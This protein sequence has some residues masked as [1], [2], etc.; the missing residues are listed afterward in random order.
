MKKMI[1]VLFSLILLFTGIFSLREVSSQQN[2]ADGLQLVSPTNCPPGGCAAG[3][4][5]NL[6]AEFTVLPKITTRTNTVL[7]FTAPLDGQN[8]TGSNPWDDYSTGWVSTVGLVSTQ[9]YVNSD[10]DGVCVKNL[11]PSEH[12]ITSVNAT[13]L[14]P[15]SDKLEL[16]LRI[17]KSSDISGDIKAYV[18][19]LQANGITWLLSKALTLNI[20]VSFY[21]QPV[22]VAEL[23]SGCG[24]FSPCFVNSGDDLVGGL[25]TGLKDAIDAFSTPMQINILGSYKVKGQTIVINAPHII[26]GFSGSS[27]T[28]EGNICSNPILEAKSG[29]KVDHLIINDGSCVN[30]SRNLIVIDSPQN[31]MIEYNTLTNGYEAIGIKPNSGNTLI[32]FNQITNNVSYAIKRLSDANTGVLNVVANNIFGNRFGFEVDCQSKGFANH[33]YWGV[34][35]DA[36]SKATNCGIKPGKQLG[37]PIKAS[38]PGVDALLVTVKPTKTSYFN[39]LLS[40]NRTSGIDYNIYL[41]NHGNNG[42]ESIPFLN[43][44]SGPM[45]PCS[46]FYDL[47]L[48]QDTLPSDLIL[49]IKY[50]LNSSCVSTI[51]SSNYCNQTNSS[52]FPLWWFDPATNVTE[53]WDMTGASPKGIGASGATGQL[54]SCDMTTKELTVSIDST[55]RPDFSNDLNFTPF[56]VGISLPA[57]IQL[58]SFTG[59]FAVSRVDLKWI[60]ASE[61]NVSGF[62][63]LRSESPNGTFTRITDKITAIGNAFVGGIYNYSD[64]DIV[65]TKSYYYKLEVIDKNGNTIEMHG[66]LNVLTATA[67]PTATATRTITPTFTQTPY[68]SNTPY[69]YISPTRFIPSITPT[70]RIVTSIYKSPTPFLTNVTRTSATTIDPASGTQVLITDFPTSQN[71]QD[72]PIIVITPII[73]IGALTGTPGSSTS[74][75]QP[76]PTLSDGSQT[77]VKIVYNSTQL[78]NSSR[79]DKVSWITI[80]IGAIVGLIMLVLIGWLL[81][82]SRIS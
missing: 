37:A 23:P 35:I 12:L 20:P 6:L 38:S 3:Q 47:F 68:L 2:R 31:V 5:L 9:P 27:I 76:T 71:T 55:G 48:A 78:D 72:S 45:T 82:R 19:E 30:I 25:G 28:Y 64:F 22:Y 75:E 8:G 58:N 61:N 62:H 33:N 13:L 54:T 66:P 73:T 15:I 80:I 81:F 67:T 29:V 11:N 65:F 26:S 7:C 50:N 14:T 52:Q 41:V 43:S 10:I 24:S 21:T 79:Y 57:G 40:V 70:R 74:E 42:Q 1:T 18:Y 69:V 16:A 39:G 32:Q 77:E 59:N 44:G 34:G 36:T 17:N 60:T 46:N 56:V 51:E 49:S 4:R 63:L 53:G